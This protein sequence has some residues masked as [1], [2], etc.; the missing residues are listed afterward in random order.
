MNLLTVLLDNKEWIFSGIGVSVLGIIVFMIRHWLSQKKAV[1][2]TNA[3]H[4]TAGD[5]AMQAITTGNN[6]PVYNSY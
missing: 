5:N 3:I 2:V 4:Q 6:S 1:P